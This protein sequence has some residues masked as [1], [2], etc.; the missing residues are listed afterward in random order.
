LT[1]LL[2]KGHHDVKLAAQD[3]ERLITWMDTNALFYGTFNHEVGITTAHWQSSR[4]TA[5]MNWC[6]GDQP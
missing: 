3:W 1:T 4:Q 6:G 5:K 2:V